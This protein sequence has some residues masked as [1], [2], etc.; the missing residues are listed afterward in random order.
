MAD[1]QADINK[2]LFVLTTLSPRAKKIVSTGMYF[3]VIEQDEADNESI[4]QELFLSLVEDMSEIGLYWACDN[5]DI[6]A[7]TYDLD[8]ALSVLTYL[9]PNTLYPKLRNDS[10]LVAALQALL[11]GNVSDNQ[12]VVDYLIFLGGGD[13]NTPYVPDLASAIAFVL[14]NIRNTEMFLTYIESLL[15]KLQ[16]ERKVSTSV[17]THK[18]EYQLIVDRVSSKLYLGLNY[19]IEKKL[20]DTNNPLLRRITIFIKYLTQADKI[21]D[22]SFLFLTNIATLDKSSESLYK[23]RTK[24]FLVGT[25]LCVDYYT[26]RDIIPSKVDIVG[27]VLFLFS[28][29]VHTPLFFKKCDN[30]KAHLPKDT[31]WVDTL[32]ITLGNYLDELNEKKESV[33]DAE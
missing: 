9:M 18:K 29:S 12:A 13:D 11:D 3:L 27:F 2:R 22:W 20:V 31:D 21:E 6:Y 10:K 30:L 25:K 33:K 16:A 1:S 26:V 5:T 28:R 23:T 19:L 32:K 14:P 15:S 7:T 4:Q 24:E 8:L 17:L